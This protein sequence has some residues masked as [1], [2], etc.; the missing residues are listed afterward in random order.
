MAYQLAQSMRDIDAYLAHSPERKVLALDTE[1]TTLDLTKASLTGF[2]ISLKPETALYIPIGHRLG[3]NVSLRGAID[4]IHRKIEDEQLITTYFIAKGDR[5]MLLKEANWAPVRFR[6]AAEGRYLWNCER[7]SGNS[8]KELAKEFLGFD[9]ARF[10]SLFTPA[11]LK[12]K[13]LDISAKTPK[14]CCDYACADADATLRLDE[15]WDDIWVQYERAVGVDMVV[16]DIIACMEYE[17]GMELNLQHIDKHEK[18]L[19]HRLSALEVVIHR[20][21]GRSF[22]INSP[23]QLAPILFDEMKIPHP[24]PPKKQKGKSGQWTTNADALE[25]IAEQHPIGEM[26]VSYRKVFR[27]VNT[28]L[29][30][31]RYL[32]DNDIAPRFT[33][34]QYRATTFRLS[35]PGGDPKSDGKTGLNAQ[36]IGKGENRKLL[37]VDLSAEGSSRDYLEELEAEEILVDLAEEFGFNADENTEILTVSDEEHASQLA[38]LPYVL[39]TAREDSD[40]KPFSGL[41]CFRDH[42]RD[43]PALCE[44]RN[45]DVTRRLVPDCKVIPSMRRAFKAPD[46]YSLVSLDYDGQEIVIAANLSGEP[47][48]INALLADTLEMRDVHA[49]TARQ[50]FSHTIEAW[51]ELAEHVRKFERETGKRLNFGTLFGAT[52][53]TLSRKMGIPLSKAEAIWE[54][55]RKGLPVLFRWIA[56]VIATARAKGYTQTYLLGRKRPLVQFYRATGRDARRLASYAD[57]CAV[58]TWVQGTGADATRIAMARIKKR[59]EREQVEREQCRFGLQIHDELM[60]IVLNSE[61]GRLLPILKEGMEFKVKSWKVQLQ[62]G[63]KVGEV[64]GQQE[65]WAFN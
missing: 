51:R 43:C 60:Y 64:W 58:N 40:G 9:M 56:D 20:M 38:P 1:Y 62:T 45:I 19:T 13:H 36:A 15:H 29:K 11:E 55:Y 22:D 46:G 35:A 8:L 23:A 6:D 3:E 18:E 65:A 50:A 30:R 10:T 59:L 7:K 39:E 28:Y 17:G 16:S 42:C 53:E 37:A 31:L 26:I 2:S 14:R 48:W 5:T 25:K 57:R 47:A 33:L 32:A 4:R 49:A 34:N 24:F 61:L 54:D 41:A 27:A 21:V 52:A 63:A 44:R 12:A